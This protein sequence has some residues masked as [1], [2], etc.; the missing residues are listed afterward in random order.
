MIFS[1][2]ATIKSALTGKAATNFK[3]KVDSILKSAGIKAAVLAATLKDE[4]RKPETG[5][6]DHFVSACNGGVAVDVESSFFVGD[7][8]GRPF[9]IAGT[10]KEFAAATKLPF[11]TPEEMFG[12]SALPSKS[13]RV[14]F[15][16]CGCHAC[17]ACRGYANGFR[18]VVAVVCVVPACMR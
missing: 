17:Y 18:A 5:M 9:D 11:K 2:Q 15:A 3:A 12:D 10:D 13:C 4:N 6:F 8:A 14:C 1:N 16:C 7:A